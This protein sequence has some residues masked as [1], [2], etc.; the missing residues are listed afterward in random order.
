MLVKLET[1][2]FHSIEKY[3]VYLKICSRLLL[4]FMPY[5]SHFFPSWLDRPRDL[6]LL[7]EVSRSQSNTPHSTGLLWGSDRPVAETLPKHK[8]T[9]TR[10][11]NPIPPVG[12]EPAIP[13]SRQPY[14]YPLDRAPAGST[15]HVGVSKL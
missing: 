11:R 1:L 10:K 2:E 9:F 13:G 7:Y 3:L 14:T 8:T 15:L 5:V 6:G 12:F 4:F